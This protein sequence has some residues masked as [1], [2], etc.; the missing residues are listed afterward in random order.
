MAQMVKNLPAMCRRPGFDPWVRKN[1]WIKEWQHPVFFPGELHGQR[2]LVGYS[3]WG[4]KELDM[5]EQLTL[6]ILR[7]YEADTNL[8]AL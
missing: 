8:T 6:I 3:P 2:S 5:T 7:P 1:P 4:C